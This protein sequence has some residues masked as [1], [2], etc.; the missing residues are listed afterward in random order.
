VTGN[1]CFKEEL[2][3]ACDSIPDEDL[4]FNIYTDILWKHMALDPWVIG[5]LDSA[6]NICKHAHLKYVFV[7]WYSFQ[8]VCFAL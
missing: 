8:Q 4:A 2:G 6:N 5:C 7:K 1:V 3:Y